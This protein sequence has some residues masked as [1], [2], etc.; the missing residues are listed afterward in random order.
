MMKNSDEISNI[1]IKMVSTKCYEI[2][3]Q[4]ISLILVIEITWI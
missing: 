2:W 1:K 3:A 4:K